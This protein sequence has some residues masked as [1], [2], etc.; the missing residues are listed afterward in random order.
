MVSNFIFIKGKRY[1]HYDKY[2]TYAKAL[3]IGKWQKKKTKSAYFIIT[4]EKGFPF[5]RR[6]YHLYLTRVLRFGF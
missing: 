1:N 2:D 4:I 6:V 5:P 3:K